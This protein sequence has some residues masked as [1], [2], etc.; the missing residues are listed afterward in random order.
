MEQAFSMY[1][2]IMA[3]LDAAMSNMLKH[4]NGR[5]VSLHMVGSDHEV[6]TLTRQVSDLVGKITP[7]TDREPTAY[8]FAQSIFFKH[9][10]EVNELLKLEVLMTILGSLKE[11]CP[12]MSKDMINW[13][14]YLPVNDDG[15]LKQHRSVLVLLL[16]NK[17][18]KISDVDM[19]LAVKCD[20]GRAAGWVDLA[21][22]FV[23]HVILQKHLATLPDLANVVEVLGK[24]VQ[25][26]IGTST[27]K[28]SKLME[29]L[30]ASG[31]G[32]LIGTG[33]GTL[34]GGAIGSARPATV[35]MPSVAL[36][37][38][39]E[40][41]KL[42][43][44]NSAEPVGARDQVISLLEQWIRVW[45]EAGGAEKACVQFLTVLQQQ[46]VLK[47]DESTEVFLRIAIE[48]VVEACFKSKQITNDAADGSPS[49]QYS[50]NVLDALSSML[51]ILVKYA[52]ADPQSLTSRVHLLNRILSTIIRVLTADAEA[53]RSEGLDQR[54]Y[55]RLL[56]NLLKDLTA[57]DPVVDANNIQVLGAFATA[58]HALQPTALPSF[59]FAWLELVSHRAFMPALLLSK[60]AQKGW[61][62]MHKLLVDLF[63]FL[64]PYLR[65]SQL[66]NAVRTLYKGTLRVLLVLLHDFPEFLC[67]YH[68]SFCDVIPASC[69]QLR[70]LFLSAFPRAMRLP[71]PF[72]P[73]L[74][75]DLLPEI[76]QPPRILSNYMA[77]LSH[78]DKTLRSD[79][80]Q[81][82]KN[83]RNASFLDWLPD[84]L[85]TSNGKDG[86]NYNVPAMNS[87]VVYVGTQAIA[88]LQNKS[89]PITHSAPMDIFQHLVGALDAEG[90]YL[91]LNAIANQLRYPNNHTHYFSCVLLYI[92]AEAN[93]EFIQEQITRVLL[94]RLIVHR[95]HPWG[96]LITFIEL[97]KNP[98]Y[99]F[100]AHSFTHCAQEIE[101]VFESV[102]RSCMGP[103][104]HVSPPTSEPQDPSPNLLATTPTQ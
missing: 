55:F 89:T 71:D 46:G 11:E 45:N 34:I 24:A 60:P 73:N 7:A 52:S 15:D 57:P 43:K 67:D 75:V 19:H 50:Y 92:F 66:P 2:R 68:F 99:N 1:Q 77:A 83:R 58:F 22:H 78:K 39:P 72:T 103:G 31:D 8:Q 96:L 63:A 36:P 88:Q 47:T 49:V 74:K 17:L 9:V 54:P 82:L 62:F 64:E 102:A 23:H 28:I 20:G 35:A 80:D 69:I 3:N 79:L 33:G 48:L 12:K 25:R 51:V 104:T 13:I 21:V 85:R 27:R 76:S 32:S 10:V 97:I 91:F 53:R 26:G 38:D 59:A 29:D 5:Q 81:Y 6:P 37:V 84:R 86:F 98:R 95:P 30:R 14:S 90:R 65:R 40:T 101:R 42:G 41:I 16:R 100:W 87:L 4:A 18:V 61:L 44:G 70:N 56:V 94:E 93:N